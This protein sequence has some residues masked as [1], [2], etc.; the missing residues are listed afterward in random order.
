MKLV[1]SAMTLALGYIVKWRTHPE[2]TLPVLPRSL[3]I[4]STDKVKV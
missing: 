4:P 3:L 2:L 1:C